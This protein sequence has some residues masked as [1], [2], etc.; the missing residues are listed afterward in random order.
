[1]RFFWITL[2]LLFVS[3]SSKKIKEQKVCNKVII[4]DAEEIELSEDE[5][6]LLCGDMTTEAYKNIPSYQA[7]F[8]ATGFLQSRGYTNPKFETV[9]KVL[10]IYPQEKVTVAKVILQSED[11]N[12]NKFEKI[13][14]RHYEEEELNPK[15]LNTIE[16][17]TLSLYRNE[18]YPCAKVESTADAETGEIKLKVSG[19]KK[20]DF[21]PLERETVNGLKEAAFIRYTSF[22]ADDEFRERELE[23][24]E[25]RLLRS[26]IVQ[27]TYFQEK[28]DL[29]NNTFSLKQNFILGDARSIRFGVGASTEVGPM[30]RVKWANLRYGEMASRREATLQA[31]AKSQLIRFLSERWFWE[32]S[33]RRSLLTQ[34][35]IRREDQTN[36]RELTAELRPH[37]KW[38][39]DTWNRY[40]HWSTGPSLI[41]SRFD[42]NQNKEDK[43]FTTVALEAELQ[44]KTHSYEVFDVHPEEG[45]LYQ[46]NLDARHPGLGF[47]EPLLKMDWTIVHLWKLWSWGKGSG[48]LGGRLNA[49]S[50][51]VKDDVA[52][53]SLP[54][55]VKHYGGGSDDVRGFNLSSLPSNNGL[56]S[57]SKLTTKFEVRKT[58]TFL[59]TIETF[60]FIDTGLFG[61]QSFTLDRRL[62]YSPGL[63]VRWLSPIGLVQ[64]YL[65]RSL[66][67]REIKD[68]GYF[69]YIGLGGIF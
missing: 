19:L 41:S 4:H 67:N 55:S 27:G 26:E 22:S 68:D 14:N 69:F 61:Q 17:E 45:E 31:S 44:S 13:L 9:D 20:F 58:H 15:L 3:C 36:Y 33:P 5:T 43:K 28:C 37:L 25:K 32:D 2:L 46:L 1:M 29:E 66:S 54:P 64:T 39:R 50:T 11:E 52:L 65:A 7:G 12:K 24:T 16:E 23:L 47:E 40:W 51:W 21:G 10:H 63:G 34:A 57:L 42:T 38:T 56:G 6:R 62:Y 48:I 59:P 18:S 35:E 30:F 49:S 8:L 53:D 60:A